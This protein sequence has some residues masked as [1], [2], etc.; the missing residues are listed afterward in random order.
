MQ[1]VRGIE[2]DLEYAH[3]V[4][5]EHVEQIK[6]VKTREMKKEWHQTVADIQ[7]AQMARNENLHHRQ[8]DQDLKYGQNLIKQL[9]YRKVQDKRPGNEPKGTLYDGI[10]TTKVHQAK[11]LAQHIDGTQG[12]EIIRK[13]QVKRASERE[14]F[15]K[16]FQ[17]GGTLLDKQIRIKEDLAPF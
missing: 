6:D 2:L 4:S 14:K 13:A 3:V 11:T 8:K 9:G 16:K 12:H 17:L 5:R 15:E 7:R 10:F 1:K